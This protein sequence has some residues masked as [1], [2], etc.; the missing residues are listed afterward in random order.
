MATIVLIPGGF[1]GAWY[2]SPVVPALRAAGH[3]VHALTLTGLGGPAD[4]SWPAINLDTHIEDVVSF[5]EQEQLGDVVLCGHSY[6][7]MV[8]AGAADRLPGRI[9]TLLF[10]DALAPRDGESVWSTWEGPFREIII[11]N[12]PDGIVSNPPPGVDPRARPHPLA[13][14]HQPV[15]LSTPDYGV[16]DK[17]YVWCS[18]RPGSPFEEIHDRVID[19]RGWRV[20]QAPCG[21]DIVNEAPEAAVEIILA[22][23]E[24][25]SLNG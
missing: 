24:R 16:E 1:H 10:I 8:I 21:H 17:V 22:A 15:R 18:G 7:G 25:R 3:D 5:I 20:L 23:A 14:F 2:F 12:S 19:E 6:A 13:C 11:V 9:R 4:R